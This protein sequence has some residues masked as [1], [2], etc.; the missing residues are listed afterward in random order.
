MSEKTGGYVRFCKKT[1]S[2]MQKLNKQNAW[3]FVYR[4]K[5]NTDSK[6]H[7]KTTAGNVEIW[8]NWDDVLS[9]KASGCKTHTALHELGHVIGLKDISADVSPNAYLMCNEFGKNYSVP[10]SI[11]AADIKGAA[12]ILGQHTVHSFKYNILNENQH[13]RACSKCGGYTGIAN[14]SFGE[15]V[16]YSQ[17]Q[18]A[19]HCTACGFAQYRDK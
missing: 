12:V 9:A 15:W 13:I 4:T 2:Q 5:A 16:N 1:L 6:N 7:Y 10:K 8:V 3:A 18:Q 11:T 19:R 14:H 17:W